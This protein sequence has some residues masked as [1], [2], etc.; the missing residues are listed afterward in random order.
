[1]FADI[2][3]EYRLE[4]VQCLVTIM[5]DEN[6]EALE[7]LLCFL[8]E[9][10]QY[11]AANGMTASN[12]ATCFAPSIFQC[13]QNFS[14][15]RSVGSDRNGRGTTKMSCYGVLSSVVTDFLS[16]AEAAGKAP[17]EIEKSTRTSRRMIAS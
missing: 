17:M 11:G 3:E 4:A 2:P 6:R 9:L 7:A 15:K 5:P 1:M 10:S 16:F 13:T 8:A 12:L 14:P